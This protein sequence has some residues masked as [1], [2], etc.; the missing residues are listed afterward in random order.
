MSRSVEDIISLWGRSA[1]DGPEAPPPP[2]D[3]CLTFEQAASIARSAE[4][5]D[6]AAREHLAECPRCRALLADFREAIAEGP[7]GEGRRERRYALARPIR[8]ALAAAA[9]VLLLGAGWAI[10]LTTRPAGPILAAADVGLAEDILSDTAVRSGRTFAT[11]DAIMFR[12]EFARKGR[13]VLIN[14]D[15]NGTM[16]VLD[17]APSAPAKGLAI[18]LGPGSHPIGPYRLVGR[19]G[20][21]TFLLIVLE[22]HVPANHGRLMEEL[23]EAYERDGDVGK[24]LARIRSWPAEVNVIRIDHVATRP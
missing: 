2:T 10:Y 14:I 15:P 3:R 19:P 6:A 23:Q 17:P 13:L 16:A 4:L 24:L 5:P 8:Y 20:E 1:G 11:G 18:V 21:E 22:E 9:A 7:P 12:V